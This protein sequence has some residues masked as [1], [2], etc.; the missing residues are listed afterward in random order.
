MTKN[1]TH[2]GLDRLLWLVSLLVVG[3]ALVLHYMGS[4]GAYQRVLLWMGAG[5]VSIT[6]LAFTNWGKETI[7]FF[8]MA[9]A[10]M[11]KVVWPTRQ[12]SLQ[13]TFVV[14]LMVLV[15]GILLWLMDSTLLWSVG[16]ITG[17]KG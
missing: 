11:R 7:E 2:T 6:C 13:M 8:Q 14:L 10:E 12:E 5:V 1:E 3:G 4:M 15:A 9:Q 17:Q 16:V